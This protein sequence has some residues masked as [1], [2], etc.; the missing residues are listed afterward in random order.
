VLRNV[1]QI[2]VVIP[3]YNAARTIGEQLD[4]LEDQRWAGTWEVIVANNRS[5]DASMSI[6]DQ[7]RRRLPNLRIIDASVRQGQPYALNAGVRAA[8]GESLLFCDADD[9][10]GVGWLAAMGQA[11]VEHE[12]VA[13]RFDTERLNVPWIYK[14]RANIQKDGLSQYRYPLYLP[15]S[16][17]GAIGV[18]RALHEIM[19]GFDESLLILHDT[20]FCWRLQLAGIT[21]HFVPEAVVHVR[22]RE[23]LR[24]IYRQARNYAKYDVLLYKRYR[25]LGMPKLTFRTS[26]SA[27]G[28]FV[29]KLPH[30]R[31]R[32]DLGRS[33][34]DFGWR[35][36][37]LQG[38]IKH[39][40]LAL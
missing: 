10:V 23:S 31:N 19:G 40:V 14:S 22:Y 5:T 11:L 30:I 21:L 7:Y 37:R 12:F 8:I 15:H 35:M 13:G 38:S 20:D 25:Y 17:G 6:V 4:A 18:R 16:G 1:M 27:W 3:C 24:D 34:W 9:V 29:R 2:S 39:H 36:G 32:E 33:M 26:V 28:K